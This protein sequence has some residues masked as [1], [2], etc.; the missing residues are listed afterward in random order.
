M[1]SSSS[2]SGHIKASL[3]RNKAAFFIAFRTIKLQDGAGKDQ[4]VFHPEANV[5]VFGPAFDR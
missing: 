5:T 4:P 3:F 1:N 2:E